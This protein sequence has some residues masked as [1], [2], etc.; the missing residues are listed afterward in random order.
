MDNFWLTTLIKSYFQSE[1]CLMYEISDEIQGRKLNLKIVID[2][3]DLF[4]HIYGTFK[5][6]IIFY[7]LKCPLD[8]LFK[9]NNFIIN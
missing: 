1:A 3:Y 7:N 9:Y 6:K 4:S 2:E 5:N 8:N